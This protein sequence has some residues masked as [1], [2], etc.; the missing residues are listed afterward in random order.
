MKAM[1]FAAGLGTRLKPITDT[2]PK[3]LVPVD[4]KPLLKIVADK[5][6]SAGASSLVINAHHFADQIVGY[7]RDQEDFGI[8]C[9]I[10][11][12]HGKPLE[13]GGGIMHAR[14]MLEGCG[15]FL[16]HNVDILSNLDLKQFVSLAH[17]DAL[18]TLHVSRRTSSRYLLFDKDMR[19]VGW[20]N[21]KT[22]ETRS[23]YGSIDPTKYEKFAFSGIHFI[24]ERIFEIMEAEVMP[25]CFSII[26]F[27]LR[28]AAGFPVYGVETEG[29]RML[30]VGKTDTLAVASAFLNSIA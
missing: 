17:P 7:V 18:A 1:I 9:K 5:L 10:S 26:D 22:G 3:A 21:E 25:E 6:I 11:V 15:P 4:G 12:E 29:F 27:Y 2:M 24:S 30:D 16:V 8:D 20:L 28:H 23:P 14:A 13:T 19:L